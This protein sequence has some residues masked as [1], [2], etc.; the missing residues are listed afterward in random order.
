MSE[1]ATVSFSLEINVQKTENQLRKLLTILNR[2]LALIQKF[3]GN[4]NLDAAIS[5]MQQAI[6][7]ANALRLAMISANM[8]SGPIGW[9]LAAVGI[10]GAGVAASEFLAGPIEA[11][12]RGFE[13]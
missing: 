5:K 4:D 10:I 6:A 11:D 2:S 1:D 12:M 3:T 7:V 13:Y 8:A 9:A